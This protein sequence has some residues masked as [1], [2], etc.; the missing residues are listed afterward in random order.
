M[1]RNRLARRPAGRGYSA[2]RSAT[3]STSAQLSPLWPLAGLALGQIGAGLPPAAYAHYRDQLALSDGQVTALFAYLIIGVMLVLWLCRLGLAGVRRGPTLAAALGV[4]AVA[5]LLFLSGGSYLSLAAASALLGC[6]VGGL[7]ALTPGVLASMM[8]GGDRASSWV[9]AAN[10]TGLAAGPVIAGAVNQFLPLPYLLVY[11][12]HALMCLAVAVPL[13]HAPSGTTNGVRRGETTQLARSGFRGALIR[14]YLAFAVGGLVTSLVAVLVKDEFALTSSAAA[15]ALITAFF[16]ANAIVGGFVIA[17]LAT[18]ARP[19]GSALL[20]M[21][22][23]MAILAVS[24]KS[25]TVLAVAIVLTGG[26]Q[27][28]LIGTGITIASRV[29]SATGGNAAVAVFFLWCY[30]GAVTAAVTVGWVSGVTSPGT[31]F[32]LELAGIVLGLLAMDLLEAGWRAS[33]D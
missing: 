4:A 17:R 18:H 31:A 19:I 3:D 32:L 26:G 15:G 7:C 22:L 29:D 33:H 12:V 1:L 16:T 2:E 8:P 25:P 27:G 10:A 14:G 20:V 24:T 13:V 23:V 5:D 30:A 6:S 9:T 21:G 11:A 28:V